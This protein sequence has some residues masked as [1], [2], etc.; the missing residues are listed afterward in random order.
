MHRLKAMGL[1][2]AALLGAG[3]TA[4]ARDDGLGIPLDCEP[5]VTCFFQQ[6]ADMKSGKG[7]LDP[8]CGKASYEGHGGT[9]IR[10]A[11]MPDIEKDV[12]VLA[13]ADGIVRAI[14][15][16]EV[17]HPVRHKSEWAR[18]KGK[19]CGNGALIDHAEGLETQYCHLRKG[20]VR[21]ERGDR[22]EKGQPI[23]SVGSSG[24]AAFPHLHITVRKDGEKIEPFTGG[25]VGS[26]C[27]KDGG[28]PLWSKAAQDFFE[29][30]RVHVMALGMAGRTPDYDKLMMEG[31]PPDL[32]AGDRATVGWGWF[33][34]L[35]KGD[36]LH[37]TITAPDG[38]T[39]TDAETKPLGRRKAV[40]MQFV[41]RGRSPARGEW[42][43][44]IDV[45]RNGEVV[46]TKAKTITVR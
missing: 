20:S 30:T 9:D 21:V 17:D 26:G 40:Y 4:S 41:G 39:F 28:D 16:G 29:K 25:R 2:A 12:P 5:G 18:F 46:E 11:S 15:D 3:G 27:L 1:L 22:V 32:K 43:L 45:K 42:T 23:G 35:Q 44:A 14:R 36:R 19:D 38:A 8:F 37:F 24:M 10:I 7:I 6:Y 34:N 31:P 13:L 33:L